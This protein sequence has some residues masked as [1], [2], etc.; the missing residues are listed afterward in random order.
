MSGQTYYTY[1]NKSYSPAV[2]SHP[3]KSEYILA[4]TQFSLSASQALQNTIAYSNNGVVEGTIQSLGSRT[5]T[6]SLEQQTIE[7][8]YTTGITVK[9]V[10]S[11]I[12]ADIQSTNIREGVDILGITGE[13]PDVNIHYVGNGYQN[14]VYTGSTS[15]TFN[16]ASMFKAESSNGGAYC[17]GIYDKDR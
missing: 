7:A 8:G 2:Q 5:I 4:P 17:S 12:D 16:K 13:I 3:Y 10:T 11:S 14:Q 9:A 15:N 6:P 1:T